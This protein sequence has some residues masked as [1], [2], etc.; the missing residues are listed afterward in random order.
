MKKLINALLGFII[1]LILCAYYWVFLE[2]VLR[3]DSL[4]YIA[5]Y[6]LGYIV[7]IVPTNIIINYLQKEDERKEKETR[8]RKGKA[9]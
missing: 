4:K 2:F 3:I 8:N 9:G 1:Y 5:V 7:F 6:I